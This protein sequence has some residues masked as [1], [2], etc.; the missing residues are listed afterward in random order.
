MSSNHIP[1]AGSAE[2]NNSPWPRRERDGRDG[3]L[4]NNSFNGN[5]TG[6][7]SA[8]NRRSYAGAF[9]FEEM[10]LSLRELFAHDR[11]IASTPESKRCGICYLYFLGSD[12]QYREEEGFYICQNC[13]RL[14]GKQTLP[15]IRRQQK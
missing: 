8:S 14:L 6:V 13:E 9:D 5:D 4:Q 15:M 3:R 12:L 2:G 11:Q 1:G 10:L 7:S